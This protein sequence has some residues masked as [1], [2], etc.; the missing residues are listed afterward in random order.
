MHVPIN[1][2]SVMF[3][4]PLLVLVFELFDFDVLGSVL[5]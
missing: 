2:A 4:D 5:M 1:S 3:L